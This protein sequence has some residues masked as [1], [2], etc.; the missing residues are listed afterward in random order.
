MAT[1]YFSLK[2][3]IGLPSGLKVS[4]KKDAVPQNPLR[5]L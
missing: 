5:Y 3:G 1:C 4:G 2:F